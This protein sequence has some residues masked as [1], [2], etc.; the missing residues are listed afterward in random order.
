MPDRM[1][2]RLA[3]TMLLLGSAAFCAATGLE[4][5]AAALDRGDYAAA[6][7]GAEAYIKMHPASAAAHVVLARAQMGLNNAPAALKELRA[8]LRREPNNLDALYFLSKLADVLA[9]Q[10]FMALARM[11][12]DSA[13]VH[14]L[15]GEGLAAQGKEDEAEREYLAALERRPGTPAIMNALGELKRQEKKCNEAQEWYAKVLEK[16]PAN[17]DALYGSGACY[18]RSGDADKAAP[19]FRAALTAD[20]SSASARMA[21]GEALLVTGKAAEALPLLEAAAKFDPQ[22]RRLQFLLAK[23]YLENGREAEAK[24]AQERYRQLTQQEE[25]E[26]APPEATP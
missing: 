9:R 17:Y 1:A 6:A 3:C 2:I 25:E 8:A 16:S 4:S 15:Q 7:R 5:C 21:L 20:P 10:E 13:R 24:Q 18:L 19:L 26:Q 12:P 11:A 14:Q 23:A 22:L